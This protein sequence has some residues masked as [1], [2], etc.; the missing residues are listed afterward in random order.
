MTAAVERA[1]RTGHGA[2]PGALAGR[3][4]VVTRPV[5]QAANL[6][7]AIRDAG[8]EPVLFPTIEIRDTENPAALERAISHLTNYTWAFFVSPNA[9]DKTFAR[10]RTWPKAVQVAAIGPG[11]RAALESRGVQE[12]L[13]PEARYDSE[14]LLALPQFA[15]LDRVRCVIFRGT[16]GR[17]LIATTLTERGARVDAVECYRRALPGASDA[18]PLLARWAERRIDAVTLT[19]SGGARN[20]DILAGARARPFYATTPAFVPHARI[21]ETVRGL[22]FADVTETGSADAGLLAALCERFGKHTP[23]D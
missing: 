5:A 17:E 2:A 1:A 9:V 15:A 16:G 20:F 8:G 12:V 11:T 21:A 19:S 13:V 14:G 18:E 22:G 7:A 10:M 23:L 4:I 3:I 6:A